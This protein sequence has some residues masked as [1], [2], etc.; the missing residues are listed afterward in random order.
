[1]KYALVKNGIVEQVILWDGVSGWTPPKGMQVVPA[2]D[3]TQIGGKFDG[4]SLTNPAPKP[5][6][7]ATADSVGADNL[8]DSERATFKA[9]A[10]KVAG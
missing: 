3:D 4:K 6:V 5:S 8:T 2:S 7:S 1:M 10:A 9:L